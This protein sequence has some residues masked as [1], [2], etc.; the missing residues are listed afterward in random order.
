[1]TV[2]PVEQAILGTKVQIRI[3]E[4]NPNRNRAQLAVALRLPQFF[5]ERTIDPTLAG[6]YLRSD[7]ELVILHRQSLAAFLDH[8]ADG[9][10]PEDGRCDC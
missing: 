5:I 10:T 7:G 2:L 1:V 4:N 9:N 8:F 3:V 6:L